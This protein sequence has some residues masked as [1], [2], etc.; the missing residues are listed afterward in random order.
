MDTKNK[1]MLETVVEVVI[2][3]NA[4]QWELGDVIAEATHSPFSERPIVG[5]LTSL[6][7]GIAKMTGIEYSAASLGAYRKTAL[8]FPAGHRDHPLSFSHYAELANVADLEFR[9]ELLASALA[10]KWTVDDLRIARGLAPK[11]SA[12]LT[13]IM[14]VTPSMVA[15]AAEL[16]PEI[17]AAVV[18]AVPAAVGKAVAHNTAATVAMHREVHKTQDD[19]RRKGQAVVAVEDDNYGRGRTGEPTK[20]NERMDALIAMDIAGGI[21][22]SRSV[23]AFARSMGQYSRDGQIN[24]NHVDMLREAVG[25]LQAAVDGLNTAIARS[26]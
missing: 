16:D 7:D 3:K 2:R 20:H 24:A 23:G 5:S 6:R 11:N 14:D 19:L 13:S 22:L 15:E 1:T 8:A 4:T 25:E 18:R 26:K 21:A 9:E 17:A 10:N 12:P